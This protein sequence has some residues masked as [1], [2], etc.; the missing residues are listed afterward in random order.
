MFKECCYSKYL[1]QRICAISEVW[2]CVWCSAENVISCLIT[3]EKIFKL[4][5]EIFISNWRQ[6]L[7]IHW[8]LQCLLWYTRF[9]PSPWRHHIDFNTMVLIE[10]I[11][12]IYESAIVW[13][14]MLTL[15]VSFCKTLH[16]E[17]EM[18]MAADCSYHEK[19]LSCMMCSNF[20]WWCK[21][22]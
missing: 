3:T 13:S 5:L 9:F 10:P 12:M 14:V 11:L 20:S 21:K 18:L 4:H 19:L 22:R 8:F 7:S 17:N 1:L 15:R 6:F 2:S 16:S